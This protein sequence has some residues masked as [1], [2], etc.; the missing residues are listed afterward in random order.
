MTVSTPITRS[1]RTTRVGRVGR[2]DDKYILSEGLRRHSQAAGSAARNHAPRHQA[3]GKY[4][5]RHQ[6][7]AYENALLN[8]SQAYSDAWQP[9]YTVRRQQGRGGTSSGVTSASSPVAALNLRLRTSVSASASLNSSAFISA[10]ASFPCAAAAPQARSARRPTRYSS[11]AT[12]DTPFS[13]SEPCFHRTGL[14]RIRND[15]QRNSW[16]YLNNNT[17]IPLAGL[18]HEYTAP[19]RAPI[20]E[21]ERR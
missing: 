6:S 10:A 13:G 5:I 11:Q 2:R 9:V 3:A 14:A 19:K 1:N 21:R 20:T 18:L 4:I 17:R 16:D 15:R 12:G 7:D 8:F